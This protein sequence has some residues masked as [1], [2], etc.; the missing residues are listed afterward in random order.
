MRRPDAPN[1]HR[2]VALYVVG[3]ERIEMEPLLLDP[4]HHR[5]RDDDLATQ[6]LRE[7]LD[8]RRDVHRVAD[9]RIIV[10]LRR[11]DVS[12]RR[13]PIVYADADDDGGQ[14]L[15]REFEVQLVELGHHRE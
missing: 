7:P 15:A 10:A 9:R 6:V 14:A 1:L 12:H 2:A 5:L 13:G 4:A 8:A 11:T 3:A